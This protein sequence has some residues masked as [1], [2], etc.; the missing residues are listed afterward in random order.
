M[1]PPAPRR[2]AATAIALVCLGNIC[3]SPMADVVL[4]AAARRRR[5]RP[6]GSRSTSCGTGDWHVGAADGPAGR[7]DA[8]RAPG[9][10]R[11]RHRARQYDAGWPTTHDLVL[12]MD[13]AQPR[14]RS[15][16][17]PAPTGS[18]L[19]RDF[20]PVEPGWRRT[21]PV[22]RWARTDSRRC[23]RWSSARAPA[24]VA[25]APA[26]ASG[27]RASAPVTRQPLVARRAEELLGASVVAT[28]PVAG[29]DI[30]TATRLRLCDGTT[31]LMKTLPHAPDGLLRRRGRR[32]ALAGRGRR[33]CARARGARPSTTSA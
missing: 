31:A 27:R 11:P 29:G 30:A 19:F 14:R 15:R 10:T 17:A 8:D 7:G 33:R 20:D 4:D 9:T 3:R 16:S 21:G 22:L 1:L 32:A 23:W 2:P 25:A 24:I 12:A 18:R 6:T 5:A 26:R 13:A 28:A